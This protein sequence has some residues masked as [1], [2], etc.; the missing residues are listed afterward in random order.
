MPFWQGIK[1]HAKNP[2]FP[3][4]FWK[5]GIFCFVTAER[6][7]DLDFV[8]SDVK[9]MPGSLGGNFFTLFHPPAW[10]EAKPHKEKANG[11]LE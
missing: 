1:R 4:F 10:G 3:E 8:Q 7:R 5:L 9:D 2:E 6:S 11:F